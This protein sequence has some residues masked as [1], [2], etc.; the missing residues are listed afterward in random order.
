MALTEVDF[1]YP[2]IIMPQGG[3]I[4][5]ATNI[6]I[7][8]TSDAQVWVCQ[9]EEDMTITAVGIHVTTRTGSPGNVTS[10]LRLGITYIDATTGFPTTSPTPTWAN[11]T[12]SGAA[13]TAYQDFNAT[14]GITTNQNL[15][16]TLTTSVTITRG[17]VFGI[18]ADPVSGTWDTSNFINIRTGFVST[19]PSYNFP[20]SGGITA[21]TYAD[22]TVDCPTFLYRSS[23][24]TYGQPY[25]TVT[26]L[27]NNSGSTPDEY[28][29]Y[30][31]MPAGSCS[32]YQV[33]GLRLGCLV[34][35]N[36]DVLL[37]DTNGTTVLASVTA[38]VDQQNATAHGAYNYL[39]TGS[40]LPTLTAGSYYRLVV[41]P[42]TATSMGP[43]QYFTFRTDADK[44][45]LLGNAADVQYTSRTNAGAWTENTNQL[46]AMQAI[47]VALDAG[48]S[49][50]GMK[51]HPG[52]S[53]GI[54]G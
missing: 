23:T 18:C 27:N 26:S 43:L 29:M 50:G 13:G 53:G 28:G 6:P 22:N 46:F 20:Y 51:V 45:A 5:A 17:T 15:I 1:L 25:E 33:A 44:T 32:T 14:S 4:T 16:A 39:F 9:A 40:T 12:F 10:G 54:N 47:V 52:L 36:F 8:G 11:A 2:R 37:Y 42:S 41:R 38:D 34:A 49:T 35:A 48:T 7:N 21:S 31:R 3:A 19:Y 30:F 24:K